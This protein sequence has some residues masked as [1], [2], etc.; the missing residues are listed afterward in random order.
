MTD[1]SIAS[2]AS[3]VC[4][5]RAKMPRWRAGQM[6]CVALKKAGHMHGAAFVVV[7]RK[8]KPWRVLRCMPHPGGDM[9]D[10]IGAVVVEDTGEKQPKE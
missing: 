2:L 10:I 5:S 6:L 4:N 1:Q 9:V 7:T 8:G 3:R